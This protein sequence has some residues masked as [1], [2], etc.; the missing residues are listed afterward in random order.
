MK[1]LLTCAVLVLAGA[2]T[3]FGAD[4][5]K[6]NGPVWVDQPLSLADA[7]NVA[8]QQNATILKAKHDLEAAY[9]VVVQTRAIL[10]PKVNGNGSYT[11]TDPD[12]TDRFPF[13]GSFIQP[14]QSWNA[15]IQIVQSFY[16]GGKMLSAFRA[17]KLTKEQA[18]LQ[19]QTVV[20]DALLAT[21]I[22]YYDV[23]VTEQQIGVREASLN[24]L[25]KELSDQQSRFNAGTVPRFNVL[26]AEV[27]VAN[28]RP[29]LIRIRN[30]HRIAKN[31]LV[32][33]LGYNLPP[34]VFED[35]PMHLT[36]KLVAEPYQIELPTALT[37]AFERRTE[38][39]ALRK[40]EKL[41]QED[42]IVARAGY[43]PRFEGFAGWGWR[44]SQY[45]SDL[46]RE[47]DGWVVGVQLNWDIFDGFLTRGK[48]MQAKAL[49]EKSQVEI[50]DTAR[51]IEVEVRTAYSSFIEAKEV[52]ESQKKVEE[53]AVEALRLA[54]ARSEA[55]AGTQLDV[56][57]AQTALTDAR[58]T[59]VVALRDYLVARAR[60]ERAIGQEVA[61][62]PPK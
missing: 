3:T 36:D 42:I 26:R 22:D 18:V 19:Y 8:I 45:T 54:S 47:V 60:L 46:T 50:D 13:P 24:L 14:H 30:L 21:R 44:S 52:L 62:A 51:R 33:S 27:A 2:L 11:D 25:S 58:T 1:R 31:N 15:S 20:A 32:N 12:A 17:A 48:V 10:I 57:D 56:L 37:Q 41:R 7:L 23:L 35:I 4:G 34:E 59:E 9:G 39:A 38:L 28:A 43:K 16:E 6:T 5:A 49:H 55:G 40:A 29:P 53:Q 61:Q